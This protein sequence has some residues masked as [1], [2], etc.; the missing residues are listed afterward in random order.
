SLPAAI[1]LPSAYT[2]SLHDAL[3]IYRQPV[4]EHVVQGALEVLALVARVLRR[5]P[6]RVEIDQQDAVP[7]FREPVGVGDREARLAR[8]ALEVQ[9]E[10][11]PDRARG[12]PAAERLPVER[13]V[14]GTVVVRSS[15][16]LR[17]LRL[18]LRLGELALGDA[19][20]VRE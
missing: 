17:E 20:Q 13:E 5:V 16:E 14:P 1:A 4:D 18:R 2:R 12:R 7:A 10:L 3:P 11:P 15:L 9:E 6:L 8:A 19:E